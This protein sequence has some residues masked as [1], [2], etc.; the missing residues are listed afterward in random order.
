MACETSSLP[1]AAVLCVLKT[2]LRKERQGRGITETF[3][4]TDVR[5]FSFI[6]MLLFLG[7]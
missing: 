6:A 5:K 3:G 7:Q 2:L 1:E 4:L